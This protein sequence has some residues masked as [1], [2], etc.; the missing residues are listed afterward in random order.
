MTDKIAL[1]F[2]LLFIEGMVSCRSFFIG[3]CRMNGIDKTQLP[4]SVFES[5]FVR[6]GVGA[7]AAG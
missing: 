6:L 7:R 3:G 5:G 2:I 1:S 4:D